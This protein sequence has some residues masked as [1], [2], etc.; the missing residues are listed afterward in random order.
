MS[1]QLPSTLAEILNRDAP[2]E[3][4]I[5]ALEGVMEY[6]NIFLNKEGKSIQDISQLHDL[7]PIYGRQ[8]ERY[9][10]QIVSD[11]SESLS[12]AS[13][14]YNENEN[15][16]GRGNGKNEKSKKLSEF[17]KPRQT[18]GNSKHSKSSIKSNTKNIPNSNINIPKPQ[19]EIF[20]QSNPS[21]FQ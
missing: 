13:S 14:E 10:Q 18:E 15:E 8:L 4:E 20:T 16:R 3:S 1:I 17:L 7:Y 21:S 5:P 19:T 11:V 9:Y 6:M 12:E 2:R